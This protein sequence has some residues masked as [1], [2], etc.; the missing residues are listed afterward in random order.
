MQSKHLLYYQLFLNYF[1][2]KNIQHQY[3]IIY[4]QRYDIHDLWFVEL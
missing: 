2:D 1:I 4:Y 3:T